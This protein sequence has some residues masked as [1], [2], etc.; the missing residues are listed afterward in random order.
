MTKDRRPD[1]VMKM[2]KTRALQPEQSTATDEQMGSSDLSTEKTWSLSTV[3]MYCHHF[4]FCCC[5]RMSRRRK[6]KVQHWFADNGKRWWN[7]CFWVFCQLWW[8]HTTQWWGD[9]GASGSS[10]GVTKVHSS[11][12][13]LFSAGWLADW[14]NES[15]DWL[16]LPHWSRTQKNWQR[17]G[18][19]ASRNLAR[20]KLL[21]L[22]LLR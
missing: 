4:H 19:S 8:V 10:K 22:L 15:I 17:V 5:Q 18:G 21:L 7:T 13:T 9:D 11:E 20:I 14:L 6:T 16:L 1:C 12:C 2:M 3:T